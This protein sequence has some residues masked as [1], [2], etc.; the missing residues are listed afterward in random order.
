LGCRGWRILFR[1]ILPAALPLILAGLRQALTIALI[2]MVA[3]ELIGARNGLGQLI[4]SSHQLFRV[5][6]MFVGLLT[7]GA[8]GFS[9]DRIFVI[10]LNRLFPW[11]GRT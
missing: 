4:S 2:V 8:I 1:A 7:L 5:D 9:L 11:Y 10:L 3:A 6:Y